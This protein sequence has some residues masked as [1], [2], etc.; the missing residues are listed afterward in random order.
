MVLATFV[1]TL[2]A[3]LGS[4][5]MA[6]GGVLVFLRRRSVCLNHM[7]L[8]NHESAPYICLIIPDDPG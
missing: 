7:L 2:T 3:M 5:A 6:F 4:A 1:V 8:F